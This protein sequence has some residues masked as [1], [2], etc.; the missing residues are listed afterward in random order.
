MNTELKTRTGEP[1]PYFFE[2]WEI[3][4]EIA[5]CPECGEELT[6]EDF[7]SEIFDY[8]CL[9][10]CSSCKGGYG[11]DEEEYDESLDHVEGFDVDVEWEKECQAARNKAETKS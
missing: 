5:C 7:E 4:E 9:P 3:P 1:L 2:D 10:L 6:E 11:W 8:E